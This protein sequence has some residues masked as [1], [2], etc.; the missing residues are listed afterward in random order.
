M[1]E[2]IFSPPTLRGTPEEQLK[3]LYDYL[4]TISGAINRNMQLVGEASGAEGM[5]QLNQQ[6]ITMQQQ[7][8]TVQQRIR[9]LNNTVLNIETDETDL[10]EITAPG[11]YWLNIS[12][13]SHKPSSV[14]T[15]RDYVM[16]VMTDGTIIKQ[17]IWGRTY[18]FMREY[19]SG[20]WSAWRRFTSEEV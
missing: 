17:L 7:M 2:R 16:Q 15:S 4:F 1:A 14:S 3:Q 12:T 9:Y 20:S 18:L 11:N 13:M 5:Q 8:A 10:N 6:M 19:Y